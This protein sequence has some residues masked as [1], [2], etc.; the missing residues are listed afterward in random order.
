MLDGF[1]AGVADRTPVR[2]ASIP[3]RKSGR[4]GR[5][6]TESSGCLTGAPVSIQP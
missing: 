3:V 1:P 5:E 2:A 6:P 4:T